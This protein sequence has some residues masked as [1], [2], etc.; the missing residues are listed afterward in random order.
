MLGISKFYCGSSVKEKTYEVAD[1]NITIVGAERFCCSEVLF[2]PKFIDSEA[3]GI[4]DKFFQIDLYGNVVLSG[5][6]KHPYASFFRD[7][8][9]AASTCI[10]VGSSEL[11]GF[12]LN[13]A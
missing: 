1:D 7:F 12:V 8:F 6:T 2:Q 13:M 11:R 5:G 10:T 9:A 3:S 4:Y